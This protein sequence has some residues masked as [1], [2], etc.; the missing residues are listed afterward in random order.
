MP[1]ADVERSKSYRLNSFVRKVS[2]GGE[3][4]LQ[5]N[6]TTAS[7]WRRDGAPDE[8][9]IGDSNDVLAFFGEC[10]SFLYLAS[11]FTHRNC[12]RMK[13]TNA[14]RRIR[15][16]LRNL[17][18]LNLQPPFSRTRSHS[19]LTPL[20]SSLTLATS[21]N[22]YST[23]RSCLLHSIT[24]E[25]WSIPRGTVLFSRMESG[26]LRTCLCT[27]PSVSLLSIH[28]ILTCFQGGT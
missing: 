15:L 19:G 22:T 6:L 14:Q 28:A 5:L 7:L 12:Q 1:T 23:R 16:R 4:R 21:I 20:A 9:A 10:T 8:K 24:R 13:M 2:S 25:R 11:A 26:L 17:P 18:P 27:C 3:D